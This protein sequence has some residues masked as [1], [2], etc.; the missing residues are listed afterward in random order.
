MLLPTNFT[1][2]I[3]KTFYDKSVTKLTKTKSQTDG[4][5]TETGTTNGTF[6]ANVQFANLEQVQSE[7]GLTE[8]VDVVVTCA[9][10]VVV[11]VDDL[12]SYNGV[13]YKVSAA[14]RRDSHLK[15]AGSKWA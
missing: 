12:I 15:I 4:W 11:A 9:N 2:I 14:L 8:R 5:V 6:K 7:M 10:D 13:T 1:D 3:A